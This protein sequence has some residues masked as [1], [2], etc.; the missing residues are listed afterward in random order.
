MSNAV[1]QMPKE[2]LIEII[3]AYE[4][5]GAFIST[6]LGKNEIY[7]A[8]F[9][10]ETDRSISEAKRGAVKTVHSIEDFLAG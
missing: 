6:V 10:Q 2:K 1:H 3:K 9:L 5:L 4:T 8:G 7:K